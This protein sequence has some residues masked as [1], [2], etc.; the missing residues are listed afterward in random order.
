M[1]ATAGTTGERSTCAV[2]VFAK[3]HHR[4]PMNGT[5]CKGCHR[6][7]KSKAQAH[8]TVCHQQFA[9]YSVADLHWREP[10]GQPPV[11]LD[12]S[13]LPRLE[14]HDEAMGPVWR[15]TGDREPRSFAVYA[16]RG[17]FSAAEC[18][19]GVP[20]TWESSEQPV[21]ASS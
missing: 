6:S 12:P 11:H 2:C 3:D 16:E 14:L 13:T 5:H 9:G 15:S 18:P 7:W 10:K 4:W 20:S 17:A 8:C 21:G 19:D 1:M